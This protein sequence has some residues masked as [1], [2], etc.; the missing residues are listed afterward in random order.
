MSK[1]VYFDGVE[2]LKKYNARLL[3]YTVYAPSISNAY[4]S[5][6]N[7][8]IPTKL[9]EAVGTRTIALEL[10]FFGE[11]P[12]E[13]LLQISN[14]TADLLNETEIQLPDGFYYFCILDK[15]SAPKLEGDTFYS[16]TFELVG[17]RHGPMQTEVLNESGSIY[18][19]GNY[20]APAKITI[21]NAAGTVV[22]NDITVKDITDTVII[23]GFDKTVFETDGVYTR[24]K[25]KSCEMTKFPRLSPGVNVID[26]TGD[27]KVTIE[28]QPIYL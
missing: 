21:E 24:N 10:E 3:H 11:T 20:N 14:M 27:A 5:R 9:K 1:P 18:A 15:V 2:I 22:V 25:F 4:L 7:S 23:N 17:Y 13:S 16:V 28:Y 26:I 12:H 6:T 8:V 19:V